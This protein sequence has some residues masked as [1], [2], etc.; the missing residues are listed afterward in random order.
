MSSK[1]AEWEQPAP[2]VLPTPP[3]I[4]PCHAYLL[5]ETTPTWPHWNLRNSD[6]CP[7]TN[8][9]ATVYGVDSLPPPAGSSSL[10]CK[11]EGGE[12]SRRT[13]RLRGS[14]R[15]GRRDGARRCW[16]ALVPLSP[17]PQ[18]RGD[19]HQVRAQTGR[20]AD[21]FQ[22]QLK[23]SSVPAIHHPPA[24]ASTPGRNLPALREGALPLTSPSVCTTGRRRC[25]LPALPPVLLGGDFQTHDRPSPGSRSSAPLLWMAL[26][27]DDCPVGRQ[28]L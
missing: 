23:D 1:S 10:S 20:T 7:E 25:C 13:I 19:R 12:S 8:L 26:S 4:P 11:M 17:D 14:G 21:I 22:R 5:S 9:R 2:H 18:G 27:L 15:K 16:A 24:P 28:C 6:L 3:S